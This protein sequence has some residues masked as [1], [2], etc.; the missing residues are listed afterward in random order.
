[1]S[2]ALA[3]TLFPASLFPELYKDLAA[4]HSTGLLP[5]QQIEALVNAGH[6]L[7]NPPVTDDQIQP[8][9]LDLRL[10]PLAYRVRA[11]FLPG[12]STRVVSRINDLLMH[13][14]DLRT[15]AVFERGCVYI[16]P[17][18]EE[19][20]LPRQISA[21]ANPKSTIGRLDV[22]TRLITDYG[23][24]YD[25]VSAGYKGHL[26]LEV[27]PRTFSVVVKEGTRLCQVRFTRGAPVA[28]DTVLGKLHQR[29]VLV[30]T[31]DEDPGVASIRQGLRISIDLK[32]ADASD[33][34]GY[35]AKR[36]APLIHLAKRDFYDPQEFWDPI[37]APSRGQLILNP[38]EFYIL[39]SRERIRVPPDH[40]A[41]MV[42]YDP[43][44]GEF[45]IH[46]AG[47][48]DPGFGYGND[49]VKGTRAILEVRS[50]EAPFLLED[51]QTVGRLIYERLLA[52]S[53]KVYGLSI[54]SSYQRQ[55]MALSKQFK[56]NW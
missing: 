49:D 52:R 5:S 19:L 37:P 50:H 20:S 45:R 34:I 46:Y 10:G 8:A 13:D 48:F 32:G 6:I 39:A 55:G 17:L 15:D 56:R 23:T 24:E 31:Q 16:I 47:F 2:G 25:R 22:F 43:A 54:G 27:V 36:V 42:P 1:M 26:Y 7:A 35:R 33:I 14:V 51:G 41:D 3:P 12:Q 38:D 44:M 40:A 30:Y 11:G 18:V 21:R 28:S 4:L 29:D 9:S 53:S